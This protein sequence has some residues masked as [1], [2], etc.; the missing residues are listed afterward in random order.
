MEFHLFD[1]AS[2]EAH[3]DRLAEIQTG[4]FMELFSAEQAPKSYEL[5]DG[6]AVIPVNGPLM[7][8]PNFISAFFGSD[9]Y[10]DIAR[11]TREAE[12]DPDVKRIAYTVNSPGGTIDGV[13]M[14][15]QTIKATSKPT[16]AYVD[17]MALSAAYWIASQTDKI[18]A[19]SPTAEFGSIGVVVEG[20][21]MSGIMEKAGAKRVLITSTDA[22]EKK[23]SRLLTTEK[24]Q[25]AM[26]KR[27]DAI[28]EVFVERVSSGRNTS[29]D[30][31]N[32]N[33]GRGG[34]VSAREALTK[35]MIDNIDDN[36]SL[37]SSQNNE[38]EQIESPSL[39][40]RGPT[41]DK[42]ELLEKHA[43]IIAQIKKEAH[44]K[45]VDSGV[46]SE[47]KRVEDLNVW[48]SKGEECSAIVD[49]AI[50]SGASFPDVQSKLLASVSQETPEVDPPAVSEVKE[51]KVAEPAGNEPI[52]DERAAEIGK[53]LAR[54][55]G[56]RI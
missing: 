21:D 42:T 11:M 52:T 14:L 35:G 20:W 46:A 53:D 12:Q 33:F 5:S 9:T 26:V 54:N 30:D 24:G 13:D 55:L 29:V 23:N 40:E 6:E 41:V 56:G 28:H 17:N 38:I 45:G 37:I 7:R 1:R 43:D 34:V 16:V 15:G 4:A 10:E 18:V 19:T 2:I 39:N 49:E 27:L 25:A 50:K 44:D 8:S 36:I 51:V 32:Q 3:L 47:R 48:R 22:P 31:I